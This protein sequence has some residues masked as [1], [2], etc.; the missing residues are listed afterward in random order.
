VGTKLNEKPAQAGFLLPETFVAPPLPLARRKTGLLSQICQEN[1]YISMFSTKVVDR[2][3]YWRT[4]AKH[5]MIR[6]A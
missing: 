6:S 1:P 3:D 4:V 5:W 2:C